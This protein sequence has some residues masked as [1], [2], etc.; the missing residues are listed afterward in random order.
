MGYQVCPSEQNKRNSNKERTLYQSAVRQAL[1]EVFEKREREKLRNESAPVLMITDASEDEIQCIFQ[2][3]AKLDTDIDIRVLE[4]LSK[5]QVAVLDQLQ[6][7]ENESKNLGEE[8]RWRNKEKYS[9]E[10]HD[11]INAA[12]LAKDQMSNTLKVARKE[13]MDSLK[14][15]V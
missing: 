12:Q 7:L 15:D 13:A 9:K 3:K 5:N 14:S 6:I 4:S 1:R 11:R 8:L 10:N 2:D